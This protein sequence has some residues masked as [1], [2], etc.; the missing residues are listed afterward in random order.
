MINSFFS[1]AS[2]SSSPHWRIAFATCAVLFAASG[3][4]NASNCTSECEN[5]NE[6]SVQPTPGS[7]T[8]WTGTVP[9]PTP[10]PN[11]TA[12]PETSGDRAIDF[13][14]TGDN[15]VPSDQ[16]FGWTFTVNANQNENRPVTVTALGV[17]DGPSLT[18]SPS[19]TPTP[20]AT[21]G[22]GLQNDHVVT[23]WDSNGTALVSGTV[24]AGTS[25]PIDDNNFR[26][27]AV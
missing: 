16:T 8:T 12:T 2:R 4:A 7:Q 10:T 20:T 13:T 26:Y 15:V 14:D 17:W 11:P 9:T 22:D 23:I 18:P 27:V 24:A 5:S 21:P 1:N 3:L 6:C 25:A 19:P